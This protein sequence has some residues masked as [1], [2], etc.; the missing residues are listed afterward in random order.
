MERFF[1]MAYSQPMSIVHRLCTY[2]PAARSVGRRRARRL[3][4]EL[5]TS[6]W[7]RTLYKLW[8]DPEELRVGASL[9]SSPTCKDPLPT[10][11]HYETRR[12][13]VLTRAPHTALL[14]RPRSAIL[15]TTNSATAGRTYSNPL[16]SL[17]HT[18]AIVPS[19]NRLT[20][21]TCTRSI[22]QPLPSSLS[23]SSVGSV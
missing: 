20:A 7:S 12:L 14:P 11:Q 19:R 22:D 10:T 13:L 8:A 1:L 6:Q 21:L 5:Q 16:L 15:S 18:S 17:S 3:T 23:P 4:S 9:R 2:Q